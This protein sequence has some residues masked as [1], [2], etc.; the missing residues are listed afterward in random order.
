MDN[1]A[2]TENGKA[3]AIMAHD[4]K[5]P[6]A[7]IVS[8]LGVINKGYVTDMVKAKELVKRAS[9]RAETL[10]SIV[11]DILDYTLL[12]DK[13]MMKREMVDLVEILEES[14][15][16]LKPYADDR[17]ISIVRGRELGVEK[18]ING[19]YT[20]L[21]R[22]FNNIVM[23]AIKYNK[24]D[25][26]ITIDCS[27]DKEKNTFIVTVTDTGIGIPK[28]DL[29]KVFKIFERG[30]HAR[31]NINGSLGLGLSLVKQIIEDHY[32]NIEVTSTLGVGTTITVTLPLFK[33]GG[34]NES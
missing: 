2:I 15:S 29:G 25:G 21:L 7:A 34:T 32:G 11:D 28:D 4:L 33:E 9:Q 18:W 26:K 23:N 24:K 30:R 8:I 14:I 10:I 20:F 27:E 17:S 12:S 6:L 1:N 16:T 22:A 31:R 3:L 19:N 13:S 5:A